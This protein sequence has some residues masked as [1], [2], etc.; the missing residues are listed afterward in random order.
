MADTANTPPQGYERL[1]GSEKNPLP[2]A[3]LIGPVDPGSDSR[4]G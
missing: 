4:K 3:K 2:N 1:S